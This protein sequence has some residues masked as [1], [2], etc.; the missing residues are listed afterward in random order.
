MAGLVLAAAMTAMA[1]AHILPMFTWM[2]IMT[3]DMTDGENW[4]GNG[5]RLVMQMLGA[6]AAILMM[7]EAG[8]ID[9]EYAAGDMWS[10]EIWPLLTMIAAGAVVGAIHSRCDAWMT[11]LVVVMAAGSLG[12]GVGGAH[13][14]ASC[15]MGD[16][17]N[18]ANAASTWLLDGVVIGVGA[19]MGTK[20]DQLME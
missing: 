5:M 12:M 16:L 15:L 7:T 18:I 9:T 8:Q 10:P 6:V 1:G 2:A 4:M 20:I 17:G 13:D 19:L 14:M 11:A 3:G